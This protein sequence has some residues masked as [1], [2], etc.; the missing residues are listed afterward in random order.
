MAVVGDAILET[1]PGFR[2]Y[3]RELTQGVSQAAENASK[4]T[5]PVEVKVDTSKAE[6]NLQALGNVAR[7]AAGVVLAVAFK[8]A[9]QGASDYAATVRKV[10]TVTGASAEEASKLVFVLNRIGVNADGI[11]KP[12]VILS[13]NIEQ[14]GKNFKQYF[15]AADLATLKTGKLTDAIPLL[16]DKFR[17]LGDITKQNNFLINVFGRSGA[18]LRKLL[19]L[20]AQDFAHIASE[21]QKFGL[22]LT[23]RNLVAF[24]HFNE[25]TRALEQS[26]KGLQVQVGITTIPI[27]AKLAEITT[28]VVNKFNTLDP[29]IRNVAGG[30][31]LAVAG[32]ATVA[33]PLANITQAAA[34]VL[35][36]AKKVGG[37]LVS[38]GKAATGIEEAAGF[39]A[40]ALGTLGGALVAAAAAGVVFV[41]VQIAESIAKAREQADQFAVA[42]ASAA[43]PDVQDKLRGVTEELAKSKK[44]LEGLNKATGDDQAFFDQAIRAAELEKNIGGL[45]RQ[46]EKLREAEKAADPSTRE[47]TAAMKEQDETATFLKAAVSNLSSSAVIQEGAQA[48]LAASLKGISADSEVGRQA[49]EKYAEALVAS[50][51]AASGEKLSQEDLKKV[52]SEA[53]TQ[54]LKDADQIEE[55]AK[56][57]E[58]AERQATIKRTESNLG[59]VASF[60]LLSKTAK[61]S[62]AE[63]VKTTE[64]NT[65]QF[66]KFQGNLETIAASGATVLAF[67]FEKLGPSAAKAAQDAVNQL[68]GPNGLGRAETAARDAIVA[69]KLQG[70]DPA[71]EKWAPNFKQKG[72]KAA[73]ALAKAVGTAVGLTASQLAGLEKIIVKNPS[74]DELARAL[75][76]SRDTAQKIIDRLKEINRIK[77]KDKGLD[78]FV[79]VLEGGKVNREQHFQHGGVAHPGFL[80][81]GE[82]GTELIRVGSTSRVFNNSDTNMILEQILRKLGKSGNTFNLSSNQEN[83]EALARRIAFLMG[84]DSRR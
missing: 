28:G 17:H 41:G 3:E 57:A 12:L 52:R 14:G 4:R 66:S 71:L 45:E 82:A 27:L 40:V 61:G 63:F 9:I 20:T 78:V 6:K 11:S 15:T 48:R 81:A 39:G 60:D 10:A 64:A 42:I 79:N 7:V 25:E 24:K 44:E 53:A 54:A 46:L 77:L 67:E 32:I 73:V 72:D 62:L 50:A 8:K 70:A 18:D 21:A 80:F 69:A 55:A 43:G 30:I 76:I 83:M 68:A 74:V 23:S 37:G 58:E 29:A 16:A 19:S 1:H 65:R 59:L 84:R 34:G 75:G 26:L 22:V 38:V 5:K 31:G 49:V 13:K 36:I 51:E 33:Q 56:K 35:P 47:F 2:T